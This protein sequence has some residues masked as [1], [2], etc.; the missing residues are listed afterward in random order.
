MIAQGLDIVNARL[1]IRFGQPVRIG[2]YSTPMLQQRVGDLGHP[3][4]NHIRIL[5]REELVDEDHDGPP[6]IVQRLW[7]LTGQ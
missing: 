2:W 6:Q 5:Q 7:A 1:E 3:L 4:G